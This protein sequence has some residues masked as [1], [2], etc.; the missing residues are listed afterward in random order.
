MQAVS[1][2]A[3]GYHFSGDAGGAIMMV[4]DARYLIQ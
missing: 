3:L 2:T 1:F 4:F